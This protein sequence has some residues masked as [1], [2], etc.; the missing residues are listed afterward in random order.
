MITPID[1]YDGNPYGDEAYPPDPFWSWH[2]WFWDKT[3]KEEPDL[4]DYPMLA[5]E[6]LF[7]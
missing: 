3:D 6:K 1:G 5:A 4:E 7:R 2:D